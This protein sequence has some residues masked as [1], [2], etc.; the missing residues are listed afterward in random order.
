MICLKLSAHARLTATHN[1][2]TRPPVA[3]PRFPRPADQAGFRQITPTDI[4]Q[5][6]RL[7]QCERYLRLR[8][9]ERSFG[10]TFMRDA[11][12][13]PQSIPPLLTR[14]GARFEELTEVAVRER[15]HAQNFADG[16]T[17]AAGWMD[18]NARFLDVVSGLAPGDTVILF[19]TRLR[20]EI[21]GW[22]LRGDADLLRLE[23][24]ADGGLHVLVADMKSTTTAKV[25]HRLQVA[26]YHEMLAALFD[27]A[28]LP[29]PSIDM[30]ILYRGFADGVQQLN[31]EEQ[32]SAEQQ[33]AAAAHLFNVPDALLELI[34]DPESYIGA[35]RDLVTGPQ[36]TALRV[37]T[38]DFDTVPYHLTYKCDGCL[39]NEFCMK[40]AAAAD[41]LSLLPHL[42]LQDKG[43]LR[44]AGVTT[45]S[46]LARLK[47]PVDERGE[48]LEPTVES[49]RLAGRLA[50]AWPVGPRLDELIHR[51]RRYRNWQHD[52]IP[53]LPWIPSKGYGSLPYVDAE[54]NPNL[55]RIYIDAQ[56]DYLNNR[57]YM[58]GALLVACEDGVESPER[59]RSVVRMT[60]GIPEQSAQ[61]E[62]LFVEW[63]TEVMESL[64][65]I[66]APDADGNPKA[67][68]HLIFYN[69]FEQRLLLDG[70]S[71]HFLTILGATPLYDFMTQLAAFDSPIATFLDQEIR[72]RKNYPMVCQS[73]QA[74]AA[75]LRF[76]WNKPE[77]YRQLFRPR[78]FDFW[79][80]ARA[81]RR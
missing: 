57:I 47:E 33:R 24:D 29:R 73:L 62:H 46:Q 22:L 30:G 53:S 71:R 41:D 38:S 34:D 27:G 17:P 56:H 60:G 55:V 7:D 3:N 49:A 52:D 79:G 72:E 2:E 26:F 59:R 42:T 58:L 45:T 54:H 75:Y 43:A 13:T 36:S 16:R 4:S 10:A 66:T 15:F 70:L 68:I 28:G 69:Q 39:Y 23:R 51:A 18:D 20:V 8:L 81:R 35:V 19:Q 48:Q 80:K 12:V 64:V 6:I 1:L 31:E 74:V 40:S 25:E 9:H 32:R 44:A 78:M 14:S 50:A 76:D 21:H 61:E 65:E 5:F 11:D 77:P 67:P 37:A 63:I